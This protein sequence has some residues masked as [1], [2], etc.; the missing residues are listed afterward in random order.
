MKASEVAAVVSG[1]LHGTDT[2]LV[3]VSPLDTAGPTELAFLDRGEPGAAGALL[4]R[5]PIPGRTTIVV[6]DPLLAMC[7]VLD[8][9][10]PEAHPARYEGVVVAEGCEVGEGT[11]LFP[12]VVLYP[13]TRIGRRCRIHAGTVIG[14]DGFRFHAGRKVPQVGGVRIG[15]DVEI[16]A[17]CTIDRGFLADT[18]LGDGCKLDDQVH[19]GHNVV[20]GK[21]VVIAAQTGISGS[22]RIGDG[23]TLGGQVG[24]A[25][26]A[27]IGAGARVGA[28][29]GVHGRIPEGEIWLGTPAQPV[30]VMRRVYAVMKD[31]PAMWRGWRRQG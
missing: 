30:A 25:D 2:P 1:T 15:D 31:L 10:F 7:A 13:G 24:V 12:N 4:V 6:S 20:L 28:Q 23:A 22:V 11:V 9:W 18:T 26:H 21:G 5:V 27:H 3:G 19:V 8:H 29:S 17:N 14:A 16:G